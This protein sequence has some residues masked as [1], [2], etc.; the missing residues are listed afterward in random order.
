[1]SI[2]SRL[3]RLEE[4]RVAGAAAPF[5]YL[6]CHPNGRRTVR[7]FAW[8]RGAHPAELGYTEYARRWPGRPRIVKALAGDVDGSTPMDWF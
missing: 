4:R 8:S 2:I 7:L 3:R 5:G 1:M 6:V